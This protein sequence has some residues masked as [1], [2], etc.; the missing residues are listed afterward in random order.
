ML[1]SLAVQGEW[2]DRAEEV[3]LCSNFRFDRALSLEVVI[4][5]E[6]QVFFLVLAF[7]VLNYYYLV[8]VEMHRERDFAIE[9]VRFDSMGQWLVTSFAWNIADKV[10]ALSWLKNVVEAWEEYHCNWSVMDKVRA[11]KEHLWWYLS[12]CYYSFESFADW[13]G[14]FQN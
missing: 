7:L 11:S 12:L 10:M 8:P 13:D 6:I 1:C 9:S 3:Q 14:D 2:L 4:V 5:A